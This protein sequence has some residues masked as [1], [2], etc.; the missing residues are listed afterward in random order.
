MTL[1]GVVRSPD[2]VAELSGFDDAGKLRAVERY[3]PLTDFDRFM[4]Y[5]DES[6]WA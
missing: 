3:R 4:G 5:P 2:D 1:P 6:V